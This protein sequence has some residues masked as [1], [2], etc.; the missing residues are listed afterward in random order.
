MRQ[1]CVG[2]FKPLTTSPSS[3]HFHLS[4][5]CV[6]H[7]SFFISLTHLPLPPASRHLTPIPPLSQVSC[8]FPLPPSYLPTPIPPYST[9][10]PPASCPCSLI[11]RS[12]IAASSSYDTSPY[13]LS[14]PHGISRLVSQHHFILPLVSPPQHPR[15]LPLD[16]HLGPPRSSPMKQEK[17]KRDHHILQVTKLTNPYLIL[18]KQLM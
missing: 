2:P 3:Y 14:I 1:F 17:P 12:S 8:P 6:P 16:C 4:S 7:S 5:T 11:G 18:R 15:V 9:P 10:L 13:V